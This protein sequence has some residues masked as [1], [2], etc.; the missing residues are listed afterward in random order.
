MS[1]FE[2][3]RPDKTV[4][5][6]SGKYKY[7]YYTTEYFRNDN[8]KP[9]TKRTCIGRYNEITKKIIPNNNYY[10]LFK[11]APVIIPENYLSF[12]FF[13]L[14]DH[15]CR[16]LLLTETL[17]Y[18]FKNVNEI[19]NI[20]MY[21]ME[22]GTSMKY[23]NHWCQDSLNFGKMLLTSQITSSVFS[24]INIDARNVFFREWCKLNLDDDYLAY[25]VTS[26]SS[27]S[28]NIEFIEYGY[29][30]DKEELPQLNIG[31]FMTESNSMPVYYNVYSGSITDKT[32][33]PIILE[34]TEKLNIK[35]VKFILDQGF[36]SK[37]NLGLMKNKTYIIS[38]PLSLKIC[39][40]IFKNTT[41][42]KMMS[43]ENRIENINLFSKTVTINDYGYDS[44][45]HIYYDQS[46]DST[47]T[48]DL[49]DH[50]KRIENEIKL[51]SS[52]PKD[53][54]YNKY[55]SIEKDGGKGIRYVKKD[56][57]INEEIKHHG[58]FMLMT[59]EKEIKSSEVI[60]RYRAKDVIEK[61]FYGIK[62][63]LEMKRL[64]TSSSKCTEGKIFVAFISLIIRN[65]IL[66]TL[67]KYM[68]EHNYTTEDIMSELHKIKI[69]KIQLEYQLVSSLTKVQK[70]IFEYF[71]IKEEDLK[72]IINSQEF[73]MG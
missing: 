14:F 61:G 48:N 37:K 62:N 68:K 34:N 64:Q 15:L 35:N 43:V 42:E 73:C 18:S 71:N 5:K 39:K 26:I 38:V 57:V 2:A 45:I 1:L 53:K 8:G 4:I 33:L 32:Q 70:E 30:R 69:V 36:Y 6:K 23:I 12:G 47:Q 50:I 25:D 19:L 66:H 24:G 20:A 49:F 54:K 65:K 7:V 60:E 22:K 10:S 59:N 63:A 40:E 56:D 21:M 55:F 58:F 27:Y 46:K 44:Y 29:N 16:E 52:I 13:F 31:M 51:F 3:D 11:K 9:R 72:R 67:K 41:K 28:S 17:S